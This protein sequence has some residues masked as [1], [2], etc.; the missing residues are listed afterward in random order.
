MLAKAIAEEGEFA[1]L[2]ENVDGRRI[3]FPLGDGE[4]KFENEELLV[5]GTEHGSRDP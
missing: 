2:R 3:Y 4:E 1:E 5:R